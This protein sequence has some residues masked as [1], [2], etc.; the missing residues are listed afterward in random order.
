MGTGGS[1]DVLHGRM[2]VLLARAVERSFGDRLVLRHAD[3]VVEVRDRVGLVGV[4]GSG[5]STLL[6]ILGGA[7]RCDAGAVRATGSV[8][9]LDQRPRLPGVTVADAAEHAVAWHRSLVRAYEDALSRGDMAAAGAAQ[10]RLDHAGWEVDHQIDSLLDKVGAPGRDGVLARLS[11]GELR[12]VALAVTLLSAPD[13]LLL[14]EPTNHLDADTAEWLQSY[15]QGY[16]GAVVLTTHDRYLLEALAERIV[17]VD[18]GLT[19]TYE[20]S[21]GDYLV[22]RAERHQAAQQAQERALKLLA[23]EA[24]WAARSPSARTGKQR[25][26]LQRLEEL[27]ERRPVLVERS[28][29]LQL[30]T[31]LRTGGTV[32]EVH[33]LTKSY[34]DRTLLRG[35]DFS[36]LAGQRLGITGPNGA[37]KTTLLR[38]IQRLEAP[39]AGEVVLASRVRIGVLDQAR[40]GLDDDDTVFEAAGDDHDQVRVGDRWVH[41]ASFLQRFLFRREHLDQRVSTLSGGERARL[42][43]ARLML[44]GANLL[45]LD[46][47]TNDLDLLTLRVLEEALLAFDGAVVVVTHDRAFLDRVC[48]GVLAFEGEGRVV[49][50]ASR[51][52]A[53]AARQR[54][55]AVAVQAAP[56]PA[57]TER[58]RT[59]QG[60][61]WREQ[62]EL[63]GL[64]SD[65]E[66]A[67][68]AVT[69]VEEVLA[70][71]RT[72]Q[73]RADEVL[74]LN[75]QLAA[76]EA[77]VEA[78]YARWE[79]LSE[80]AEA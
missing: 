50:Y 25:A 24:A 7:D 45:L 40:T 60:L 58:P 41:V 6:R 78:L 65:I 77:E 35:A 42:L 74:A 48:T 71:P 17:E 57:P 2:S 39:D 80:R 14:D 62:R 54:R 1:R 44:Q 4:N 53:I 76:R 22:A 37:G 56:A 43:L 79:E 73:E 68:A 12:R 31:G 11:G 8:G 16:R 64:E 47:P 9:L 67:E 72:Y 55:E 33:G 36:I 3:L 19:V 10:D 28:M 51:R 63:E 29:D 46:E 69:A 13:A 70:D 20:G 27:R 21:Y 5:K 75:K 61:S 15:L 66:V 26:R 49:E 18:D 34:G 52:Q 38:L 23:R 30:T 32:L 59:R